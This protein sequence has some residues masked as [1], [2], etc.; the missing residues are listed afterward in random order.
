MIIFDE[1]VLSA[2][3]KIN[4]ISAIVPVIPPIEATQ[5]PSTLFERLEVHHSKSFLKLNGISGEEI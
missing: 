2:T 3:A 4:F 5:I 1:A